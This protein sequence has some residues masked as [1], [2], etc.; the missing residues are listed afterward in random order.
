MTTISQAASK[1]ATH[2]TASSRSAYS[3]RSSPRDSTAVVGGFHI[4]ASRPTKRA[5]LSDHSSTTSVTKYVAPH[6]QSTTPVPNDSNQDVNI[7]D[8]IATP[9]PLH[10]DDPDSSSPP[11]DESAAD[12][13]QDDSDSDEDHLLSPVLV[14]RG[15]WPNLIRAGTPTGSVADSLIPG[16]PF[17]GDLDD[18]GS[19]HDGQKG[20]RRLP[21]RRRAPNA[22]PYLEACLRRQLVLRMGHRAVSKALKPVLIELAIRTAEQLYRDEDDEY[23]WEV[24]LDLQLELQEILQSRL[25]I[26][27]NQARITTE[28]HI[29]EREQDEEYLQMQFEVFEC[30]SCD[31]ME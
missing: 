7:P 17:D 14:K 10:L 3:R 9:E 5:R 4:H 11:G 25:E 21:G 29:Q 6:S 22:D 18:N 31:R 8:I 1:A 12:E 24:E 19:D 2:S 28:H 20:G 13:H 15:R 26:L 16:S 30:T 23:L 27:D